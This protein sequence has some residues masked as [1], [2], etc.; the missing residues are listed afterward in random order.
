MNKI[1]TLRLLLL[2]LLFGTAITQSKAQIAAWDLTG[3]GSTSTI[4]TSAADLFNANL[5]ASNLL[6]RGPGAAWSTGGNSF[7]TTGFQNNGISTANTD[8]FQFTLSSV[9]GFNLSLSSIDAR[10]AGTATFAAS[11]GVSMQFAY[12]IDGTTFNLIGS[13]TILIGTPSTLPTINLAGIG[14]LQNIPDNV[15]VTFRYY[16]TGQTGTG[17]WGFNSP[18]LGIYGLAIGG[19]TTP[20]AQVGNTPTTQ[21]SN[22]VFGNQSTS[23]ITINS[24]TAGNG[25]NRI[26][27]ARTGSSSAVAPTNG[28]TYPVGSTTGAGNTIIYNGNGTGPVTATGLNT[29]TQYAFDIYEYN[30]TSTGTSYG[31]AFTNTRFTL[32]NEP[33]VHATTFS[34]T[35]IAPSGLTL[36]FTTST[37]T[38]GYIILQR[39]GNVA[40]TGTPVD[41]TAYTAGSA[42]GDGTVAAVI[43]TNT[44]NVSISGLTPST[45]YSFTIIPFGK[46]ATNAESYNYYLGGTIPS[47]TASTLTDARSINSISTPVTENFNSLGTGATASLPQGFTTYAGTDLTTTSYVTTQSAGTGGSV[48]TAGGVYNFGNGANATATDRALGF[49]N[50]GSVSSPRSIVLKVVNNTGSVITDLDIN[51]DYEKYRSG[52]RE[53]DWN[54]YHGTTAAST[55]LADEQNYPADADN[56]VLFNPPTAINKLVSLTGLSIPVGAEYFLKWTFVGNGGSTNGQAIGIDNVIVTVIDGR[57]CQTPASQ[58]TNLTFSAL[59]DSS[60]KISFTAANPAVNEYMIVM[61]QNSN[62]T[63]DPEDGEVYAIGDNVGDGSV[64]YKGNLTNVTIAGLADNTNYSFFIFPVNSVCIGGP[65]YSSLNLLSGDVA[66]PIAL[67]ACEVPSAQASNLTFNNVATKSVSASFTATTANEYV[68]LRS[69][70]STLTNNP[71][72]GTVYNP[73]DVI[74]NAVVVQRSTATAFTATGLTASTQYYF[75]V[76]S[77]NSQ[78]CVNGPSYNTDQPLTGNETTLPLP[79][80]IAPTVQPTNL[81]FNA[82]N[83]TISG[84]FNS[85]GNDYDYLVVRSTSATLSSLPADN[86]DYNV[87][88]N[89]GGGT[90]VGSSAATSFSSNNLS[91]V[92]TYYYFVF[93]A[94]KNCTGGTKYLTTNP[95]SGSATTTNTPPNNYYFGNLHS[96]SDYSDGNQDHPGFKPTDDWNYALGSQGMDF[97][98]ISEHNHF[99][100]ANN[101]GT[102]LANYHSGIAEM[103]AFNAAHPNFVALYGMEW[104][105]ISGGGHVVV[106]GDNMGKLFGWESNVGGTTGANYDV[107]VPKSVYTGPTGL[108]KT[109][110]DYIANNTFATLAHPNNADYNNL[111]NVNYDVV[112]DNAIVGTAVE[113]GPSSSTNTTY[114]NP[115]SS[116][117]YLWYY[118][119]LLSKGYHLGPVIDHDNHKTTFGRTTAARTAVLAPSLNAS[120]LVKAVREM[121][122]YS[123]E[124]IDAKV[125]FTVNARVM[126][127]VFTDRNAPSISVSLSDATTNTSNAV[128]RIMFGVPGSGIL[129]V[130]VD[131]VIGNSMNFVHNDLPNNSTGYYYA[132]ITNGTARIITSPIWYTRTCVITNDVNQSSC[133]SYTWNDATYTTSGTYSK[134]FATAAGCDSVVNLHLII[135]QPTSGDTTVI[136]C[137]NFAWYGTTYTSSATPTHTFTNAAGCDSVVTL[138]LTINNL[139]SVTVSANGATTV[140]PSSI[141]ALSATAEAGSG[142]I[143]NY[144]WLLNGAAISGANN[145]NYN[146]TATGNYSVE[147][148]NSNTCSSASNTITVTVVD[149]IAPVPDV[150]TLPTITGQCSAS[151]VAPTATDNCKGSITATTTDATS[152]TQQGTY[153]INWTYNDGNENTTTQTQTVIVKDNVAPIP[154]VQTLPTINGQCSASVTAPTATDNC[155]GTITATTTDATTYTQQ[156]T[157]TITW[158]YNDGNGNTTTQTQTV[159]V[160][161]NVAPVITAP[162]TQ[163]FCY[164]ATGYM[165]PVISATDNCGVGS[166][167]F[168]ITGATNRSGAGANATGSFNAG[169]STITWTVTDVNG[170]SNTATTIVNVNNAMAISIADAYAVTPGGNANTIYIGYG[171]TSLT[172]NS[173]VAGGTTPYVYS[174]STGGTASSVIVSPNVVGNYTYTVTATDAKG[175]TVTTSKTVTVKDVRSGTKNDK[176]TVCHN[177]NSLSISENAVSA[178]LNHGDVLGS[179]ASNSTVRISQQNNPA[180]VKAEQKVVSLNGTRSVRITPVPNNGIFNVQLQNYKA[181]TA[182]IRITDMNSKLISS[183]KVTTT[184]KQ[185]V[186]NFNLSGKTQG[187]YNVTIISAEGKQNSRVIIQR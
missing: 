98:G 63:S 66:T 52:S 114:S 184:G 47:L 56:N 120:E 144:Q 131:S 164:S 58:P 89:I 92:T 9:S 59:T 136:A 76:Y 122:F 186:F 77:L 140:C 145:A 175:C 150:E 181:G 34:A 48:F 104:G 174:W 109:I 116:M 137:N 5:D 18:S 55:T 81:S 119:K 163:N 67:P 64:V 178:H 54:F 135:N 152:F 118:Q 13:P 132:D 87:G 127:S 105:V 65:K 138:H 153:T 38:L 42:L 20:A 154:D 74:G 10:F 124:D 83:T 159:V 88:D 115:A 117:S 78:A 35:A 185:D 173:V 16:A 14:A 182:E 68:V 27:V 3:E 90:V 73:G 70:S 96:H 176:V 94:N 43:T 79:V 37:S 44:S 158:T 100:S 11:P 72:T 160:A 112:A 101:P 148:T 125:D 23:T 168:V 8:Y 30:G 46:N 99:S 110:N 129:P 33:S 167:S 60:V 102:T 21:S 103:N 17:G 139:P 97:L 187:M 162:A 24:W 156:G 108:F 62:L 28:S 149:N 85:S 123:T 141:V 133:V 183:K 155:K 26:V 7:R 134:T 12:S 106:Y 4:T 179:C 91:P 151:V 82:S 180:V 121:R 15:T 147:V 29:G 32:Q 53:F 71:V 170:N 143:S 177:G 80:C 169:T 128:I 172:L 95:L 166:T 161:D 75:F 41:G 1:F 126:G 57:P 69:T 22:L 2:V 19:T 61:S 171:A 107:F 31:T 113:S 84:T 50:S 25:A 130:K 146:A 49:L 6:T 39:T 36:N 157:F 142:T 93:A 40:P 86:T 111:S 51:F 165:V 45:Q